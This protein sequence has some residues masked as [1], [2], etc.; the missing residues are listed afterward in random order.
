MMLN[1]AHGHLHK[2][3]AVSKTEYGNWKA[4]GTND[5]NRKAGLV[6]WRV[7]LEQWGY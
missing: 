4:T 3:L 7:K 6:E 5:K 1:A 2:V